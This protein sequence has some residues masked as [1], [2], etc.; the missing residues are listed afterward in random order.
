MFL[1][2]EKILF[3][4]GIEFTNF[5]HPYSYDLDIFGENSLFQNLNRTYTY[6]GKKILSQRLL[7]I[8]TNDEILQNQLA[9]KELSKDLDWRQK[10]AAFSK[11]SQDNESFYTALLKWTSFNSASLSSVSMVFSFVLP[12]LLLGTLGLYF[13]TSN[14]VFLSVFSF[15]FTVNLGFLGFF[16]KRIVAENA[17]SPN[18]DKVI[19]QYGL[20]LEIIESKD[21]DS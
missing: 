15:I 14:V 6:I 10:F 21:F 8:L 5:S 7:G 3:E 19:K 11:S 16:T 12:L 20:L 2:K 13:I 1:K 9:I 17:Q 18:I 4:D